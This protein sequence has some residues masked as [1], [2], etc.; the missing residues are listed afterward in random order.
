MDMNGLILGI[1][2]IINWLGLI[3]K[4]TLITAAVSLILMIILICTL[5]V[6][7]IN[8]IKIPEIQLK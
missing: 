2:A 6:L 3:F 4:W 5:H 7:K 1:E 8:N